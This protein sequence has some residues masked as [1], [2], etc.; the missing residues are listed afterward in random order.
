M[1]VCAWMCQ[2]LCVSILYDC[3]S[4]WVWT[5]LLY[6][7]VIGMIIPQQF[8]NYSLFPP[9]SCL[10]SKTTHSLRS[11]NFSP[12]VSF[13]TFS[14]CLYLCL[15]VCP[16]PYR[17]CSHSMIKKT[18]NKCFYS[19]FSCPFLSRYLALHN[20]QPS[21]HSPPWRFKRTFYGSALFSS[22]SFLLPSNTWVFSVPFFSL[23]RTIRVT[24]IDLLAKLESNLPFAVQ[25][26]RWLV[27]SSPRYIC[28]VL[29]QFLSSTVFQI[30]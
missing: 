5:L 7:P 14:V 8:P 23:Y 9:A 30:N 17:P 4:A 20:R 16:F 15:S 26:P 28:S 11:L 12:R 24:I 22:R 10:K 6:H 25:S 19:Y 27:V 13:D 3:V 18:H 21:I 2:C 1:Y 29:I